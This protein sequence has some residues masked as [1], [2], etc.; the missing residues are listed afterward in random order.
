VVLNLLESNGNEWS[1]KVL[2][3]NC[4]V[5]IKIDT[6]AEVNALPANLCKKLNLKPVACNVKIEAFGG[7]VVKPLGKINVAL[8]NDKIK[9]DTN[10]IVVEN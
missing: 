8:R 3:N 7:F 4:E 1:E 2:L 5:N 10:F 9:I 6:G